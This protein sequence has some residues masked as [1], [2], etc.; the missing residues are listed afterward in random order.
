MPNI[1]TIKLIGVKTI[2][3]TKAI[4]IGAITNPKSSQNFIQALFNG[5]N[6]FELIKPSNK[7]IREININ[8]KFKL[9]PFVRGHNPN[10]ANTIK[11]R[12]P[13]LLFEFFDF[14]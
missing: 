2:K 11:N 13:K 14:I 3:Y 4:I 8:K 10:T 9:Y 7:K 6:N 1:L 12:K 5:D